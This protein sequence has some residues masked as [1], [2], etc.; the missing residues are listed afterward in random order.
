LELL[1]RMAFDVF[2]INGKLFMNTSGCCAG[3][4][5]KTSSFDKQAV[6]RNYNMMLVFSIR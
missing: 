2:K 6:P 1:L 5:E 3:V 4:F